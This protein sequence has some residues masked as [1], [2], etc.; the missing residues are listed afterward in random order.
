MTAYYETTMTW[1][2]NDYRRVM[3]LFFVTCLYSLLRAEAASGW[4]ILGAL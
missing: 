1:F 4:P 2:T 3:A